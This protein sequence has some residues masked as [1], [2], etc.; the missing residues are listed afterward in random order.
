MRYL[1]RSFTL[2]EGSI[3]TQGILIFLLTVIL[4]ICNDYNFN[5]NSIPKG[6]DSYSMMLIMMVSIN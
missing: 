2:G 3:V 4:Q 6:A 1:P 5:L